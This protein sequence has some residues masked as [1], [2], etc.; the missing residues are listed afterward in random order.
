MKQTGPN[1]REAYSPPASELPGAQT[2][3]NQTNKEDLPA[4]TAKPSSNNW[5]TR[6]SAPE[7]K[8]QALPIAP[9]HRPS[10][11]KEKVNTTVGQP[12]YNGPPSSDKAKENN[13]K[14]LHE[15][16][17]TLS[18]PGEEYGHPYM[19]QG[20]RLK[21][22]RPDIKAASDVEAGYAPGV[23]TVPLRPQKKQVG[24][25]RSY[26]RRYYSKNK[27]KILSN[28]K[29]KYRVLRTNSR[30][31]QYRT[32]MRQLPLRFNRKPG[33]V[34]DN[35]K[36][37]QKWRDKQDKQADFFMNRVSP[38]DLAST[39]ERKNNTG[40]PD[41]ANQRAEI[42]DGT[43]SWVD[44]GGANKREPQHPATKPTEYNVDNNP[45]S[46]KVIPEGH[47]FANK[48]ARSASRVAT[49]YLTATKIAEIEANTKPDIKA[50]A[51]GIAVKLARVDAANRLWLFDVK[52]SEP[53]PYRV[54]V[55]ALPPKE[56]VRK[57]DKADVLLSCSCNF[58]QWQ[59]PEYWAKSNGYLYGK[60][61]GTASKPDQKDPSG[62]NWMCKH[63]AAVLN[64]VKTYDIP[65]P[66]TG[67]T[68]HGLRYLCSRLHLA[69]L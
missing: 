32:K 54:R 6:P 24:A 8:E 59:G 31:K 42:P 12:A 4:N 11:D 37:T 60:P 13:S 36:R 56:S 50:K 57:I 51:S 67:K 45:G 34:N 17:R 69:G 23:P 27:G 19:D 9:D 46:A 5:S 2:F 7:N 63:V 48:M 43:P 26:Y 20:N 38:S 64:K 30:F 52:G 66:P 47:D 58:W 33:G 49:R 14:P 28:S 62:K 22:R 15:R 18:V 41:G 10:R 16:T 44:V 3:V 1:F 40:T 55:Q 25:A 53:Q 68:A 35:A 39:W 65:S 29:R 21:Q 61:K